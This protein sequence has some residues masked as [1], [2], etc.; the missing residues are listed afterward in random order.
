MRNDIN[1][2]LEEK[3]ARI[4]NEIEAVKSNVQAQLNEMK[5]DIARIQDR[6]PN[7]NEDDYLHAIFGYL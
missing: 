3:L 6:L 1:A 5:T 4:N 7:S 2:K